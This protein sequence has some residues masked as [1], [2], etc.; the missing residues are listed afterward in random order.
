MLASYL[1]SMPMSVTATAN[2]S[3]NDAHPEVLRVGVLRPALLADSGDSQV[4]LHLDLAVS[5]NRAI[6]LLAFLQAGGVEGV[7]AEGG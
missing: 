3:T 7:V 5:A 1:V 2:V 6:H 4:V